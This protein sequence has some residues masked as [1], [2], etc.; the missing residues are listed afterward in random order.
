M[1]AAHFVA[2]KTILKGDVFILN[3]PSTIPSAM[4]KPTT[5]HIKVCD[6]I[7]GSGKTSAAIHYMVEHP[8]RKYMYVAPR[9]SE[10][11]R[12]VRSC[13]NLRFR[14]PDD[15]D[16]DD[17][18]KLSDLKALMHRGRNVA[19]THAL[20]ALCDENVCDLMKE[21]GYTLII[22]EVVNILS[23]AKLTQKDVEA[24]ITNGFAS[25]D[26][27][28]YVTVAP[29]YVDGE[30]G[31]A[32][33]AALNL[34]R[35]HKLFLCGRQKYFTWVVSDRM[36]R[37]AEEVIILTYKFEKSS[38]IRLF[39]ERGLEYSNIFVDTDGAG[40][41]WFTDQMSFIPSYVGQLSELITIV[42]NSRL[43]RIGDA[44]FALSKSWWEKQW[45]EYKRLAHYDRGTKTY[46]DTEL[47]K[48]TPMG[49]M[50]RNIYSYF[51]YEHRD[52]PAEDKLCGGFKITKDCIKRKGF[53]D[54]FL[55]FNATAMNDY[56]NRH[57]LAYPVNV[58]LPRE[59]TYYYKAVNMP[60]KDED[61][62]LTSMIQWIWRSAIRN[63]EPIELYLPSVRMRRILT[64][65]IAE[66]EVW[67]NT[68]YGTTNSQEA[69]TVVE[70]LPVEIIPANYTEPVLPGVLRLFENILVPDAQPQ[71]STNYSLH[72]ILATSVLEVLFPALNAR[73]PQPAELWAKITYDN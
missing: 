8:D 70:V 73:K 59:L 33:R 64:K 28:G 68:F 47:S 51:M 34:A 2:K 62:A 23:E 38:M 24:M 69:G 27:D 67:Y 71:C 58:F 15:E 20:F 10:D 1:C 7:M 4:L 54:S 45:K 63:G 21:Q 60:A 13:P 35:S 12:I 22:D 3:P 5:A 65:W 48:N 46:R 52:I 41:Y 26:K 55:V 14:T 18:T 11:D 66:T 56:G 44:P 43:N 39:K 6:A 57:I 49:I 50:R 32:F 36:L 25:V 72:N 29:D 16:R 37:A 40:R 53:L 30:H 61:F 9:L 42:D 17:V 19:I 31:D